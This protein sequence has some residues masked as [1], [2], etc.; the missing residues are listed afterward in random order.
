MGNLNRKPDQKLLNSISAATLTVK[1]AGSADA[2]LVIENYGKIRLA[3]L[4]KFH[5]HTTASP[6][7][8]TQ[9]IQIKPFFP[10]DGS[11]SNFEAGFTVRRTRD[12][13]GFAQHMLVGLKY[14]NGFID[15]LASANGD[16]VAILDSVKLATQAVAMIRKHEGAVVVGEAQIPIEADGGNMALTIKAPELDKEV[17]IVDS[18]AL[19]TLGGLKTAVEGSDLADFVT[20]DDAGG[21]LKTQY[22]L[23]ITGVANVTFDY[24]KVKLDGK[25]AIPSFTV[26]GL[27]GVGTTTELTPEDRSSFT[28]KDVARIFPIK[29]EHAGTQPL[30]P[31]PGQAYCKYRFEMKHDM[32]YALDGANHLDQYLEQVEFYL[33]KDVAEA[34]TG[35]NWDNKIYTFLGASSGFDRTK[36]VHA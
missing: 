15:R 29:W 31:L 36:L 30:V 32:G 35:Q 18:D 21:L 11:V 3:N 20:V 7:P 34:S 17:A 13:T 12:L 8:K 23:E 27:D 33:P 25:H 5:K 16:Y 9:T 28:E 2:E 6:T 22:A 14:Y 24:S 1:N 26:E 10:E 4:V 19:T